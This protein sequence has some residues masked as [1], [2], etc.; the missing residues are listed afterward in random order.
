[1]S[2]IKIAALMAAT[3]IASVL[4][5]LGGLCYALDMTG[6]KMGDALR[7]AGVYRLIESR[8]VTDVDSTKLMDGAISGMI[9]SLGDPHSIYLDPKTYHQLMEQTTGSFGGIGI[10]M[11]FKDNKVSVISV[12]DDSPA[13][14]A[15]IQANDE[16]LAVDGVPVT[17]IQPEEVAIH[18]RGEVGTEVTLS[19]RRNGAEDKEFVILRDTI[20][21]KTADGRMLENNM[22]YIRIA[23]FSENTAQEFRDAYE[24]LENEGMKGLVIDLRENPGGL[25]TSSVEIA[26]MVVPEGPV[27]SVVERDGG[28]EE[29]TSSLK[30]LKY[31]LVVLIDGNSASASEILAG[32]VQ[33][34]GAGT[35][36]GSKSFGKGS[37]Q[38]VLPM[39]HDDA[40][41][42][43]IAK[44]YTPS[45][46]SI[47]GVGI[48]PD[49]SI[50]FQPGDTEDVQLAKAEEVLRTKMGE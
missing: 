45:G 24:A 42:L 20:Q 11:G 7:F 9:Q 26:N 43:T 17:E 30:E 34:T 1:M 37:V 21:V 39:F 38:T 31:P 15:G 27:V 47:D 22:G 25:V 33:D 16:I 18:I 4:L 14:K 44:Y 8:Y 2:K 41:K 12:M 48:E 23:A 19:V 36:V 13:A 5:T 40:V 29:Y 32:A 10:Y 49:V 28:K 3:S 50:D 46:R 6:Q 35:L